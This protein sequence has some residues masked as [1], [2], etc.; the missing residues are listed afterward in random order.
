MYDRVT[1]ETIFRVLCRAHEELRVMLGNRTVARV[2]PFI[3]GALLLC[4]PSA[5]QVKAQQASKVLLP[6]SSWDCGMPEGIAIPESGSLLFEVE[7][8]LD[9]NLDLGKTPYGFRRVAVAAD[10]IVSSSRLSASVLPGALDLELTLANGTIEIEQ[11]LVLKTT[12]G[13]YIYVRNAG[14]GADASDTRVVVDFE[15]PSAS[16]YAWLNSGKYVARRVLNAS[17]KIMQ[18]RI[19]DVTVLF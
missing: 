5:D 14:T 17:G 10:G 1:K 6:H 16:S 19:Y 3:V 8:K 7:V 2:L 4:G 12:D 18:M 13:K 11:L 15:A 9:R